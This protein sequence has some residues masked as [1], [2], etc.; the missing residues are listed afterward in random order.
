MQHSDLLMTMAEVSVAFAGFTGVVGVFG[1][2]ISKTSHERQIFLIGAMIGFSLITALFS[3]APLILSTLGI[4]DVLV[5]RIASGLLA[6]A[7]IAWTAFGSFE[8]RRLEKLGEQ[9]L[10]LLSN[11]VQGV[12]M[13]VLLGSLFANAVGLFATRTSGVYVMGTFTP[14]VYAGVYFMSLVFSLRSAQ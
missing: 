8:A 2:Q 13:L 12:I 4:P 9:P 3:F 5:W 10:P 11:P 6:V 7:V 14:L 1:I